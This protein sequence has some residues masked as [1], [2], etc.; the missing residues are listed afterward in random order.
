M[1]ILLAV[2][3]GTALCDYL[4][5]VY[6]KAVGSNR[7]YVAASVG[8]VIHVIAAETVREYVLDHRVV[9]ALVLGS[10]FGT[11]VAMK[12]ERRRQ[13]LNSFP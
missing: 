4:W 5:V 6:V 9:A 2:F 8:S 10:F 12:I 7:E 3:I 1:W 13:L 11:V